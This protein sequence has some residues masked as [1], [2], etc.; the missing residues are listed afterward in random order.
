MQFLVKED[1][2]NKETFAVE[3]ESLFLKNKVVI[4]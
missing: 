1:P 4:T 2:F 3:Y